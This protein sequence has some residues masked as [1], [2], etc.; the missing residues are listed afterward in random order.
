MENQNNEIFLNLQDKKTTPLYT[1]TMEETYQ[2]NFTTG[3][4]L[5]IFKEDHFNEQGWNTVNQDLLILR[6]D[7]TQMTLPYAT[8]L[9][10]QEV[11]HYEIGDRVVLQETIVNEQSRFALFEPYRLDGMMT[12]GM[13]FVMIAIMI[14][15]KSGASSIIGLMMSIG[16]VGYWVL[17]TLTNSS[18]TLL[19]TMV[20]TMILSFL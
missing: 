17:P 6:K 19:I 5:K 14:G 4:I 8:A 20:A 13:L 2:E 18:H 1:V 9:S 15:G 10:T 7:G 12:F 11:H 16:I 3:K